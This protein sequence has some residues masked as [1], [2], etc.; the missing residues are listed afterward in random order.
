MTEPWPCK[1]GTTLL[2]QVDQRWPDR[3]RRS[4]GWIGDTAHATR[5]SDHNPDPATGVVR[6]RDFD[7]DL[8]PNRPDAARQLADQLVR[9]ARRG[10]DRRRLSYVIH[11]GRIASGTYRDS[12]WTW[13]P[14]PGTDPHTGHLHVSFTPR[15]DT[16]G[17]LFPLPVFTAPERRRLR[18]LLNH[19]RARATRVRARLEALS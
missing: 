8:A 19:L 12:W 4:D 17:A 15:G 11:D 6:A 13:R 14:Y 7:A 9:C 16:G 2:A 10:E 1:A 5:P 18:R 3:D